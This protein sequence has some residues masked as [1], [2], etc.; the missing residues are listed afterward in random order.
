[1]VLK[2]AFGFRRIELRK[3]IP[4]HKGLTMRETH[5]AQASIFDFYAKHE[6]SEFFEKLSAK[7]DQ[8]PEL[9]TLIQDDLLTQG[10]KPTG[11]KG[12]SV[13]SVFRCLLLKQIIGVSYEQL[14]FLLTDSQ[15]YRTFA[16]LDRDC[17]PKKSALCENIRRVRPATLQA[18]FECLALSTFNEGAMNPKLTRFDSTVVKSHI[19]APSDSRLPDDGIRVLSRLFA[20]SRDRTGVKLRLTDY[21]KR[22]R[23]LTGAIFYGQKAEKDRLYKALIPLAKRVVEQSHR[24]IEQVQSKG[25]TMDSQCWINEVLH[26]RGLLERV[27][28]QTERRVLKGESVPAA[29]KLVSLFEPH[30]D[31]I[32]KGF[33]DIEYGHKVNLSTDRNGFITMV[34]IEEGNP[35]D[36]ERFIPLLRSHEQLYGILP[37]TTIADGCYASRDNVITAKGLGVKR[38]AF[39]KKA[40]VTLGQMGIKEKTL[41][42][43]RDFRAGIEG[44]ISQLK[45]AFGGRK[46]LWKG[47]SGFMAYV[48]ASVISYNLTRWVRLDSG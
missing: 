5:T 43:L 11:R 46:A 47:E 22:S 33:R 34:M 36:S 38:V 9:V 17:Y 41:K 29:E 42:K 24:A 14:S 16:R 4:E 25:C 10:A 40:G 19:A 23:K 7:L 48:W 32:V 31:I 30:T 1:M 26:Y 12:L 6:R 20:Q 8:H 3:T 45:R 13:E 44:N 18:V 39:H 21:R 28:D 35:N 15:S 27:I 37:T 2:K